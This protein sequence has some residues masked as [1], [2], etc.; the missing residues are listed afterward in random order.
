MNHPPFIDVKF[1]PGHSYDAGSNRLSVN[2]PRY[3]ALTAS[4]EVWIRIVT[5][6][7]GSL[8]WEEI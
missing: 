3:V 1:Y 5:S 4:G 7:P 2:C 6:T 8:K